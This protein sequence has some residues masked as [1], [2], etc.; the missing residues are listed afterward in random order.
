MNAPAA[1]PLTCAAREAPDRSGPAGAGTARP[2][3]RLVRRAKM[4]SG[5]RITV[6][7]RSGLVSVGAEA[8]RVSPLQ[9]KLLVILIKA[10]PR[11]VDRS[12]AIELLFKGRRLQ[13]RT[14]Y[15]RRI[16]HETR[17]VLQ[18]LGATI[19][20]EPNPAGSDLPG[21]LSLLEARAATRGRS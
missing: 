14:D 1:M 3:R 7:T 6:D 17:A 19:L 9:A 21:Y 13:D 15:F 10:S 12:R 8:A 5:R 20:Y 18:G 16:L 11:P 2:S 4:P